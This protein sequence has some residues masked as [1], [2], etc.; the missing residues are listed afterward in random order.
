VAAI[1][2]TEGRAIERFGITTDVSGGMVTP[3]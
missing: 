1:V 2:L 3:R